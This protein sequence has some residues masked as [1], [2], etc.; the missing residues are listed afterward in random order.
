MPE[1]RE[2]LD[3]F[4]PFTALSDPRSPL[5]KR[6][7]LLDIIVIALCGA[8]CGVDNAEE[9]QEFGEAK[10]KWFRTFL[11]LP[12][13]IPS[14]DTFLRVFAALDPEEFRRC[15]IEWVESLREQGDGEII[16]V[17]GKSIRRALDSARNGL[18]VHMVNAWL[19]EEGLVIGSM[20]TA[21]KSNE[22]TA[23][24]ELLRLLNIEGSTV[25]TDA[26]GCQRDIAKTIVEGGGEYMLQVADNHPAMLKDIVDYFDYVEEGGDAL[27]LLSV[28][29][30]VDGD[31]GRVEERRYQHTTDIDWYQNKSR[32]AGLASFAKVTA[33]RTDLSTG[34]TSED[35]RYY[36]CSYREPNAERASRPIRLHWGV[37]NG[38]HW[39][40][41]MAF[42]EDR[43]RCR[44]GNAAENFAIVRH[45]A[46]N[47]IKREKTKKKGVLTKRKRCGWD[48]DYLLKVL[49]LRREA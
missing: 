40:L 8:I 3:A 27:G 31:H 9:L 14:Q 16:A 6:H 18:C 7:K 30:T 11:E 12:H 20:R 46:L 10:E 26:M 5:G 49:G 41:D 43:N 36:I 35:S 47:L 39:V 1:N 38:L 22:I 21:A 28:H 24:P 33:K 2:V 44:T 25:T 4:R 15:F 34:K 17:D 32:W 37:E 45:V 23:I 13:G 48:H 29:E 42:D 19:S